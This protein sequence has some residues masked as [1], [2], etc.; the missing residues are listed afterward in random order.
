MHFDQILLHM[1]ITITE[2][3]IHHICSIGLEFKKT[4]FIQKPSIV[5]GKTYVIDEFKIFINR[6]RW[7]K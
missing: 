4:I 1:A 5:T 7:N 6:K 2:P 3:K